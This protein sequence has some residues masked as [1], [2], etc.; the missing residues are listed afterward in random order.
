MV[1]RSLCKYLF[2]TLCA[3][4]TLGLLSMGLYQNIL[5]HDK[6]VVHTRSFFET[7][8]DVLPAMSL[9]FEQSFEDESF[10]N[11]R[12]N[13]TGD[14]YKKFLLGE[15]F[16]DDLR[17]INYS[18]V[19]SKISD[20]ILAYSFTYRNG[21]HIRGATQNISWKN[22][23]HTYSW[24]SWGRFVKCFGIEITDKELYHLSI[25]MDRTLF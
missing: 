4:S 9:C 6:S 15:Y 21:T 1:A 14:M 7:Q 13:T 10:K 16:R 3:L 12:A 20:Y 22:P 11:L 2:K 24:E 25:Y 23:Y 5:V 8:D 19:T 18:Q 17:S